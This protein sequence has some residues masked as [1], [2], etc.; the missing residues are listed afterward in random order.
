MSPFSWHR[1][2]SRRRG[3]AP[4]A[5]PLRVERLD[6]RIVPAVIY[7]DDT[8]AGTAAGAHP[9]PDP[10][11]GLV[12]GSSAFATIQSAINAVPA[13]STLVVYG[14]AYPGAV[15]VNKKNGGSSYYNMNCHH[16]S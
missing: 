14:G 5:R 1:W 7:V 11:G 10:V 9:T 8:W 3:A 4:A 13:G 2:L 16:F 15:N 12:F 6:D